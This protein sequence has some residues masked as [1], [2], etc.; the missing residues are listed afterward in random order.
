MEC[1]NNDAIA[2][3]MN[4]ADNGGFYAATAYI[5]PV[6]FLSPPNVK[7]AHVTSNAQSWCTANGTTV[8]GVTMY[9]ASA[10]N[11]A[12]AYNGYKATGYWR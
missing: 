8:T 11:G 3:T 1:W 4:T 5:F 10:F 7:P 9:M 12:T 2:K 6:K